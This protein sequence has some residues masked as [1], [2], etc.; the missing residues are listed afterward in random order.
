M[1]TRQAPRC[2]KRRVAI[3]GALGPRSR[4][5]SRARRVARDQWARSRAP[6]SQVILRHSRSVSVSVSGSGPHQAEHVV[7]PT[8]RGCPGATSERNWRH[9]PGRNDLA[10][11]RRKSDIVE[12]G[13]PPEDRSSHDFPLCDHRLPSSTSPT[14]SLAVPSDE[15]VRRSAY[16]PDDTRLEKATE[17]HG[18]V[19]D[20][21]IQDHGEVY[22]DSSKVSVFSVRCEHSVANQN[23]YK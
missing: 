23:E 6:N 20:V 17:D 15:R 2:R 3:T 4:A 22:T 21:A 5:P 11:R 13:A 1:C 12:Y 19:I 14:Y 18:G 9:G 10:P 7:D 8:S 16:S